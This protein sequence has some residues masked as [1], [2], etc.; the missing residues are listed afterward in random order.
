MAPDRLSPGALAPSAYPAVH[1]LTA[2]LRAA[3][4]REGA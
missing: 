2:P 4:E 3:A 1:H